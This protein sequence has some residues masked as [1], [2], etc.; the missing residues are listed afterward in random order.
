MSLLDPGLV[1][2][3]LEHVDG[4]LLGVRCQR[5]DPIHSRRLRNVFR[6]GADMQTRHVLDDAAEGRVCCR[7]AAGDGLETRACI[8]LTLTR[9]PLLGMVLSEY[10]IDPLSNRSLGL[11]PSHALE[12]KRLQPLSRPLDPLV[13]IMLIA[14]LL[15]ARS[16]PVK[17]KPLA[18]MIR[19]D[20][21][22]DDI[23]CLLIAV[24]ALAQDLLP[25]HIAGK[26]GVGKRRHLGTGLGNDG[27]KEPTF[28]VNRS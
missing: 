1:L 20:S 5:E 24:C 13:A 21:T 19:A 10:L 3:D 16:V 2:V 18:Q 7:L 14:L 25:A 12:I 15:L 11:G 17:G 22:F 8:P 6:Y 26:H 28:G 27:D 23:E 4:L 9:D